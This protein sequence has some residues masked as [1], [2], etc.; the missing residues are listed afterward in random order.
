VDSPLT[1]TPR[2]RTMAEAALER[3]REAIIMGELT[4]GTPLRLEDLARNLGMSISPIREAVRQ[5][6]ALGLA[7]HVPHHGAKVMALDVEELR[8]LFSIRL[9]L[10][11]MALRRAAELFE[12]ADAER[13]RA[14]LA[15]YDEARRRGDIRA[16][17]RAHGEF[18]FALYEAARSP[19]L[20]RLIRPAW[21]SCERYRPVL[22]A[23]GAVQ[24]RH[25]EIDTELLAACEAHDPER[26]AAALR[27]HLETAAD[28]YAVEL[29]GRS[30]FAF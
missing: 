23:K 13:A 6:E 22:F 29:K 2:H 27:E 21:D 10:E 1:A 30:I 18:H 26:A 11:S 9:A 12:P 28:I 25:E 17:V 4:P 15:A 20:V 14:Q 8:E 7:E 3:L 16:A 24:D 19:W 5:L